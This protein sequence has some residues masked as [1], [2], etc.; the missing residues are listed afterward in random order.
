[1]GASRQRVRALLLAVARRPHL[2]ASALVTL[3]AASPPEWWRRP[4]F[5]PWPDRDYVVWRMHTAYG[6]T[7]APGAADLVDYLEWVRVARR[8]AR[9][10]R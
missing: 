5:V 9:R 7:G 3:V 1:M 2:W 6:D 10:H 8:G 4:P